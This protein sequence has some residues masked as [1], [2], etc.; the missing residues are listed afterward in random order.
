[1]NPREKRN[2]A[3]NQCVN[4]DDFAK[5]SKVTTATARQM[6]YALSAAIGDVEIQSLAVFYEEDD[7]LVEVI[8]DHHERRLSVEYSAPTQSFR[9][10]RVTST[11]CE[12][13]CAGSVLGDLAA[14]A[15]WLLG[16]SSSL[17][18]SNV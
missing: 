5:A 12:R 2:L 17:G 15:A 6:A 11:T 7:G 8:A 18:A 9:V 13:R 14:D 16:E 10:I 4:M 3:A 1:M